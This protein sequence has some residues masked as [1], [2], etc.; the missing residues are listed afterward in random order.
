MTRREDKWIKDLEHQHKETYKGL[1]IEETKEAMS[2]DSVCRG[3]TIQWLVEFTDLHN[4]WNWTTRKVRNE[5][6]LPATHIR[7]CRYVELDFM[8]SGNN[9]GKAITFVSHTWGATW[10]DLVAAVSD[11]A[12]LNRIVWV[13]IFAVRQWPSAQPDLDCS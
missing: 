5:I 4:C 11:G 1:S 7:H 3:V 8:E 12:D 6:I 2:Q 13:D 10:G 9:V